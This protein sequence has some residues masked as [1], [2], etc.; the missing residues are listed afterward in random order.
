MSPI[1]DARPAIKIKITSLRVS[2]DATQLW[3]LMPRREQPV[4][5]EMVHKKA[6]FGQLLRYPSLP[7][8]VMKFT[9]IVWEWKADISSCRW[10]AA[11]P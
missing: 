4:E 5:C 9:E 8:R 10:L 2:P 7:N 1:H 6:R 3:F 11:H